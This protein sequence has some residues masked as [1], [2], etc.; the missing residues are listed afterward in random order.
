MAMTE[1]FFTI[2]GIEFKM[3]LYPT[4]ISNYPD[5]YY[6]ALSQKVN[7]G[8]VEIDVRQEIWKDLQEDMEPSFMM[9]LI[10]EDFNKTIKQTT[11][12]TQEMTWIQ[13]LARIFQE[14]LEVVGSEVK[15][16]NG[17]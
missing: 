14:G 2:K 12:G 17:Y 5:I 9:N 15:I 16:K 7:G 6:P 3:G 10:L 8:W 1:F 13:K 11:G 4:K